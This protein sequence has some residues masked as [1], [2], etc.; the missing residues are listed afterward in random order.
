MYDLGWGA[1]DAFVLPS[2]KEAAGLVLAEAGAMGLPLVGSRVGGIP[3]IVRPGETGFLFE[4]RDG[5]ALGG[6]LAALASDSDLRR[7]LGGGAQ[8]VVAGE[9]DSRKQDD[10]WRRLLFLLEEGGKT[11][12]SRP[13]N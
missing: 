6:I 10:K 4:P 3:E 11:D 9:F 2:L 12:N 7:R 5:A 13:M 8:A 1:A